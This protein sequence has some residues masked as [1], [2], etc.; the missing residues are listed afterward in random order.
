ML[1]RGAAVPDDLQA[2]ALRPLRR[3]DVP[4]RQL[5]PDRRHAGRDGVVDDRVQILAAS[6]DIDQIDLHVPRD[7]DEMVV[8]RLVVDGLAA[9]LRLH[10]N[11]AIPLRAQVP[12]DRVARAIRPGG[13]ADDGDRARAREERLCETRFVHSVTSLRSR[14]VLFRMF[15]AG[16]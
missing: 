3:A 12:G 16:Y 10:G 13:V 11:D 1:D 5:E 2:R 14:T 9:E 6:E 7:V 4:E 15:P 8:A